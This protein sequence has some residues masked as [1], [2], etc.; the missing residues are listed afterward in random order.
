MNTA[1][2]MHA[3]FRRKPE[4]GDWISPKTLDSGF[5]RNDEITS[6]LSEFHSIDAAQTPAA[7]PLQG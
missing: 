5:R 3:S 7:E 1:T 4:S 6:S 2:H